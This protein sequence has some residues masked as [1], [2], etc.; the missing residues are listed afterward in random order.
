MEVLFILNKRHAVF[1]LTVMLV[2]IF[3]MASISAADLNESNVLEEDASQ[4]DGGDLVCFNEDN[5]E[6]LSLNDENLILDENEDSRFI[7]TNEKTKLSDSN[8]YSFTKLN[9]TI[10]SENTVIDLTDN[11]KYMAGDESFVNGIIINRSISI[12]GNGITI[13]GS[14]TARIFN[15]KAADVTINNII[16]TNGK[17][18]ENSEAGG[19]IYWNGANGTLSNSTFNNN[20]KYF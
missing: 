12:N 2:G 4:V 7:D 15:I 18:D 3:A 5:S 9:E 1:L 17:A 19:A 16:F 13:D 10:N 20:N 11:Y 14:N 8:T 6:E